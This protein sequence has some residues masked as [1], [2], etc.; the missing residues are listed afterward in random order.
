MLLSASTA[1]AEGMVWKVSDGNNEL[2]IGGTIHVLSAA[3][4]PLPEVYDKAY[5]DS[6]SVV[7]ETDLSRLQVRDGVTGAL[8]ADLG[9][10][11]GLLYDPYDTALELPGMLGNV[12]SSPDLTGDG[13]PGALIPSTDGYLYALDPCAIELRWAFDFGAPVG[14][15][16]LADRL[17]GP[18]YHRGLHGD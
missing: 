8:I 7:L 12:T 15:A 9:L 6:D 16:I 17:P 2:Y 1:F 11:G 10:H 18:V 3:D 13:V 14:E 5:R 4:Y